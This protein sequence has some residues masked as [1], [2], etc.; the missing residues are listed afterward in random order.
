MTDD[1]V[2]LEGKE[3]SDSLMA[4]QIARADQVGLLE[5]AHLMGGDIGIGRS[6]V[7]ASNFDSFRFASSGQDLLDGRDRRKFTNVPSL[8]LEVDRLGANAGKSS[9]AGFMGSQFVAESQDPAHKRRSR[10]I[11]DMFRHSALLPKTTKP[12][13]LYRLI[14]LPSHLRFDRLP[15]MYNR[16]DLSSHRFEWLADESHIPG[17]P[18]S[19]ST[20]S[21]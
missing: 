10:P 9:P 11:G 7:R 5:V 14:H 20:P 13:A 3:A 16:T 19:P 1:I 4:A 18:S 2:G 12:K 17:V 15:A 21:E 6:A 8:E